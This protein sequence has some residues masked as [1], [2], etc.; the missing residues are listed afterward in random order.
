[1]HSFYALFILLFYLLFEALKKTQGECRMIK[2]LLYHLVG[3][4]GTLGWQQAYGEELCVHHKSGETY[5]FNMDREDTLSELFDRVALLTD[6]PEQIIVEFASHRFPFNYQAAHGGDLGHPRDYRHEPTQQDKDDIRFIVSTLANGSLIDIN[7][8][9]NQLNNAGDRIDHLHPYHF[10]GV[11]F[12]DDKMKVDVRNL[13]KRFLWNQFTSGLKESLK[14]EARYGNLT[15]YLDDF[16]RRVHISS[17]IVIGSIL[18]QRWEEFLDLL[19]L[20]VP[21]NNGGDHYGD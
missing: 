12:S 2:I 6:E 13:R 18:E 4:L 5:V 10:C 16:S 20:H 8:K 7:K 17:S 14:T 21:L 15:E 19:V 11:I 1:L 3:I 9:K